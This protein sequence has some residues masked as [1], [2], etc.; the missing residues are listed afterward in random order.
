MVFSKGKKKCKFSLKWTL[1]KLFLNTCNFV[2]AQGNYVRKHFIAIL[3]SLSFVGLV[4]P[5]LFFLCCLRC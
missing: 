1:R 2:K 5:F 4:S 3:D